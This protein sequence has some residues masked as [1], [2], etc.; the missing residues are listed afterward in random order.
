MLSMESSV[1]VHLQTSHGE[2]VNES[3]VNVFV[4]QAGI[5]QA[6]F[7]CASSLV[8]HASGFTA[9]VRRH[10]NKSGPIVCYALAMGGQ[11]DVVRNPSVATHS[12]GCES[13]GKGE[14]KIAVMRE[15]ISRMTVVFIIYL[16]VRCCD[17]L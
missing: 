4:L 6:A 16:V 12:Q 3:A 11:G 9:G 7:E 5:A 15:A 10:A 2:C 14:G 17:S 13:E 8:T 1:F